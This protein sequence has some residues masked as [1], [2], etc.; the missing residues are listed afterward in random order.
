MALKLSRCVDESVTVAI[1]AHVFT[2]T[3]TRIE[4][5]RVRLAFNAPLEFKILRTE[6]VGKDAKTQPETPKAA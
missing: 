2:C 5:G 1:G 6:I 4:H 3:V